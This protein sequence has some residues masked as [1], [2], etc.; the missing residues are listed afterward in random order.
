ME[1][2]LS[3]LANFFVWAITLDSLLKSE[4]FSMR[5]VTTAMEMVASGKVSTKPLRFLETIK[6]LSASSWVYNDLVRVE[7][8]SIIFSQNASER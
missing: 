1:F 2:P 5:F 3:I 4:N 7:N 6:P 8:K